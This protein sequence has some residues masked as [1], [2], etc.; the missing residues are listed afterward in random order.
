MSDASEKN[1]LDPGTVESR[2]FAEDD[3]RDQVAKEIEEFLNENR[4]G[5]RSEARC[6][7]NIFVFVTALPCPAHWAAIHPGF[8][9]RGM[10]YFPVAGGIVGILVAQV[11][12]LALGLWELP[13]VVA[14]ALSTAIS[15]KITGCFHED[16]LADT[17]DGMGG[18]WTTPQILRIMTDS[19]LGT[20]GSAALILY[21]L[22]KIQLLA[23]LG[24]S[25][26]K[27]NEIFSSG[28]ELSI[29]TGAGPALVTA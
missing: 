18:G 15:L 22:A 11:F 10:C 8:L 16:G 25:E 1:V 26:W 14:S 13:V 7:L 20:F 12:D 3:E 21:L 27:T 29:S 9:M 2:G 28:I 5:I 17:A 4:L 19:R 6:F 23:A 24:T